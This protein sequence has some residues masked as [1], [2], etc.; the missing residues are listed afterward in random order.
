[1]SF[2]VAGG[3]K[4]PR[5]TQINAGFGWL[6][7][8]NSRRIY[9]ANL[10]N[11]WLKWQS[12]GLSRSAFF[13]GGRRG[14]PYVPGL[15]AWGRPLLVVTAVRRVP[16]RVLCHQPSRTASCAPY[17]PALTPGF[18]AAPSNRG[19]KTPDLRWR[20]NRLDTLL[21]QPRLAAN[22]R[23]GKRPGLLLSD[24]VSRVRQRGGGGN[25]AAEGV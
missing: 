7:E 19:G 3:I 13:I 12:A 17:S 21:P 8:C 25:W 5:I 18:T 15:A 1:M 24:A 16:P 9:R 22:L 4:G 20:R 10:C 23:M 6:E 2:W 11:L 14:L